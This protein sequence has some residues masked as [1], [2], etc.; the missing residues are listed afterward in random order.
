ML[1]LEDG[2]IE[3][4]SH[5]EKAGILSTPIQSLHFCMIMVFVGLEPN[6]EGSV[7]HHVSVPSFP[8]TVK[9]IFILQIIGFVVSICS[10]MVIS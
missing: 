5:K 10:L 3:V 6:S 4:I 1:S 2:S 8:I 7:I 9:T